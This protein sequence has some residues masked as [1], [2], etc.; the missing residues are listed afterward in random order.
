M[1]SN[2]HGYIIEKEFSNCKK[3]QFDVMKLGY[4]INA[5]YNK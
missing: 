1:V 4:K 5:P 3:E 2:F